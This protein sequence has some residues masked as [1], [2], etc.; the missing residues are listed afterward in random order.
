MSCAR[1]RVQVA[2]EQLVPGDIVLLEQGDH[3]SADC[4]LIEAFGVRVNNAIISGESLPQ[5][6]EAGPCHANELLHARNI[7]LAGTSMVSGQAKAVGRGHRNADRARQ[8]RVP[9]PSGRGT[10]VRLRQEIEHLSQWIA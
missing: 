6:R 9:R 5:A 3:V 2:I 1:R 7:V 8:D 4:R 10:R